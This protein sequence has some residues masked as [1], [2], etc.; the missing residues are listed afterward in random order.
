MS[1]FKPTAQEHIEK[2]FELTTILQQHGYIVE[3]L[4]TSRPGYVVYEDAHQ[5]VAEP[6]FDTPT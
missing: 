1:W 3:V 5:I 6:F 2:A 4:R